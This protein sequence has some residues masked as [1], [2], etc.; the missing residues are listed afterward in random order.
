L[1]EAIVGGL[2]P[3]VAVESIDFYGKNGSIRVLEMLKR[4]SHSAM[5]VQL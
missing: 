5:L 3:D 2:E 4:P 1:S